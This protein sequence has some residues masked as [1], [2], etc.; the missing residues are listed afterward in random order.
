MPRDEP[1]YQSRKPTA[2][3]TQAYH[4]SA[5]SD[6]GEGQASGPLPPHAYRLQR[7]LQKAHRQLLAGEAA[8]QAA[9]ACGCA[10][11]SHLNRHFNRAYGYT[12]GRLARAVHG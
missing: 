4:A 5:A 11:Q 9:L 1:A 12:P 2:V 7:Q 8:V 10:D 3:G 6:A